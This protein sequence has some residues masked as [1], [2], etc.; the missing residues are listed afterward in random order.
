[1]IFV[2]TGAV[3]S[4]KTTSLKR[5]IEELRKESIVIDGYLSEVVLENQEIIGYDLFDL[6]EEKSIPFI[7][8]E[9]QEGWERVGS[10]SVIPQGLSRAKGIIFR[11]SKAGILVVDEVGPLELAGKGIWPALEKVL[12][13]P[14]PDFILV[15]RKRIIED[16]LELIGSQEVKIF[17][18]DDTGFSERLIQEVKRIAVDGPF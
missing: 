1:M 5:M 4:G 14:K 9:G 11:G 7:H 6:K 8:R 12:F 16:F 18:T 17:D 10:Y 3:H 13:L 2:L 15:V